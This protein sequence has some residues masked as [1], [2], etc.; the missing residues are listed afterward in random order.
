LGD[1]KLSKTEN[2]A[3]ARALSFALR[4]PIPI[5]SFPVG[6]I[7]RSETR[8]FC[9]L[10]FSNWRARFQ[11]FRKL[12]ASL[13]LGLETGDVAFTQDSV[14]PNVIDLPRLRRARS[15]RKQAA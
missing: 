9:L 14:L 6:F 10:S 2:S 13:L 15:L 4:W 1:R 8:D 11:L 5:F 12:A 7:F 3:A